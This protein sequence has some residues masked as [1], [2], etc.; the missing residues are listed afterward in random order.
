M[1]PNTLASNTF[2]LPDMDIDALMDT[3]Q[4]EFLEKILIKN[5][6]LPADQVTRGNLY[7]WFLRMIDKLSQ[8]S[9]L[10]VGVRAR[11]NAVQQRV[12]RTS[13]DQ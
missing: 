2:V 6:G 8:N 13:A 9:P 11:V 5:P 12:S 10:S 4:A 7:C 1:A 3:S